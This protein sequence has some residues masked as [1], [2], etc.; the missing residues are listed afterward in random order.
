MLQFLCD[1]CSAVK[2]PND[3]WI[4]GRAA[5]TVGAVSASREV[6]VQSAWDRSSAVHPL[7]VH[8]C[9]V[10]CKDGYL[11]RLFAPET[12]SRE[13]TSEVITEEIVLPGVAPGIVIERV[14]PREGVRPHKSPRRNRA[15]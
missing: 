11:A 3:V 14:V 1:N 12:P 13:V 10:Q 6:T 5:E 4:V 8:F 15:A 7:A 2:Q 9:S